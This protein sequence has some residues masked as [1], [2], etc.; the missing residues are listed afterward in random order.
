[1]KRLVFVTLSPRRSLVI[2]IDDSNGWRSATHQYPIPND[3]GYQFGRGDLVYGP[4]SFKACCD[5][6]S[7][8]ASRHGGL[9]KPTGEKVE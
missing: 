2:A 5:A 4:A 7:V 1:M 6:A 9:V 8:Y 3:I